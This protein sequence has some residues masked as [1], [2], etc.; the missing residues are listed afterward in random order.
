MLPLSRDKLDKIKQLQHLQI[1]L[2]EAYQPL[3]PE[4]QQRL[5]EFNR[6][7]AIHL[8]TMDEK[9]L[10]SPVTRDAY[11]LL[12]EQTSGFETVLAILSLYE[13]CKIEQLKLQAKGEQQNV[14]SN[15]QE[16]KVRSFQALNLMP[17]AAIK[18]K[19]SKSDR[20]CLPIGCCLQ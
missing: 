2:L 7:L 16:Q 5:L 15:N 18:S 19:S 13:I 12:L 14:T 8:L 11:L 1:S 4:N 3:T 9:A 10:D 17:P 6:T 20:A